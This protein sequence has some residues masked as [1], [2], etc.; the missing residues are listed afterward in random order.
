[1]MYIVP[2]LSRWIN[3]ALTRWFGVKIVRASARVE[4]PDGIESSTWQDVR[5]FLHIGDRLELAMYQLISWLPLLI[6]CGVPFMVIARK[7]EVKRWIM[8]NFPSCKVVLAQDFLAIEIVVKDF[9]KVRLSLYPSIDMCCF[10]LV[11]VNNIRHCFIGH[12]DS[13]KGTSVN[14]VMR[15]FDEIWV[16]SQAHIDRFSNAG[17]NVEGMEYRKI[18][19]P[20]LRRLLDNGKNERTGNPEGIYLP[21]WEGGVARHGYSSVPLCEEIISLVIKYTDSRVDIKW[22]PASGYLDPQMRKNITRIEKKFSSSDKVDFVRRECNLV[23]VI[24]R[25][26]YFICDV[27]S[28]VTDCLIVDMPIFVY[29]PRR[30]G[31]VMASSN[32]SYEDYCYVFESPEEL[33]PLFSRVLFGDDFKAEKRAEAREYFIGSDTYIRFGLENA[34]E[35]SCL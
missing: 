27:S 2:R 33:A 8:R 32:M 22:H 25:Y 6:S 16:A 13:E 30:E 35:E 1:M 20:A 28:V 23:D 14:K 18:G 9:N 21:T 29:I 34:I 7:P 26:N 24:G 17:F 4:Y 15:M 10:D 31:L 3:S 11:K 19:R 5:Y 12:G